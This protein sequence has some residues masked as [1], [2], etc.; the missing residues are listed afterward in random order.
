MKTYLLHVLFHLSSLLTD[1][2]SDFDNELKLA[3]QYAIVS[4]LYSLSR[5]ILIFY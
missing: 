1:N 2:D 5:K 4:C 3:A